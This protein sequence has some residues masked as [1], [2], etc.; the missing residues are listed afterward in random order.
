MKGHDFQG[1]N[2]A[3]VAELYDRYRQDPNSVD[4]A[5]RAE[6]DAGLIPDAAV[7]ATPGGIVDSADVAEVVGTVNLAECIR[8]YGHLAATLDPL[9]S[10]PVGDPS[11]A[12]PFHGVSDGMLA[13]LPASLVGGP[14]AA[15]RGQRARGDHRAA[16]DLLLHHRL[17][18]LARLRARGARLA[19]PRR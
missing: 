17:R 8:R 7:T 16:A 19:A 14:V 13:R 2:A 15:D 9:G 3:Y 18:L 10:A 12:A 4:A 1:V 11:L 6:F 5:T